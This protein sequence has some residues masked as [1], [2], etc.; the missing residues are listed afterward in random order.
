MRLAL[1]E[2]NECVDDITVACDNDIFT[3]TAHINALPEEAKKLILFW[4]GKFFIYN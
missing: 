1:G 2:E 4:L 3:V